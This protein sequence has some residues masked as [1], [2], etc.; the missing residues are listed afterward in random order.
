MKLQRQF[1]LKTVQETRFHRTNISKSKL[2]ASGKWLRKSQSINVFFLLLVSFSFSWWWWLQLLSGCD[3]IYI[4]ANGRLIYCNLSGDFSRLAKKFMTQITS[5]I[6]PMKLIY[7]RIFGD[8]CANFNPLQKNQATNLMIRRNHLASFF[9]LPLNVIFRC[10]FD[11]SFL[12]M[13]YSW[14][15]T[16]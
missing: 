2:P 6:Q 1:S 11:Y 15:T 13:F 10:D 7:S 4:I 16:S 9:P 8:F 14:H 12:L 3:M 5:D